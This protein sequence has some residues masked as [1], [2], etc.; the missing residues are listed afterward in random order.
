MCCF[1]CWQVDIKI[2]AT[3]ARVIRLAASRI[4][5]ELVRAAAAMGR[6]TSADGLSAAEPQPLLVQRFSVSA[7]E[8]RLDVW[9]G[10]SFCWRVVGGLLKLITGLRLQHARVRLP[11]PSPPPPNSQ[12]AVICNRQ[13]LYPLACV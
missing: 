13:T 8:L 9:S 1:G 10:A 6:F 7:V 5:R 3:S 12:L 4:R 11:R 2:D